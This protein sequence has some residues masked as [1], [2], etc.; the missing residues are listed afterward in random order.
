ME[1]FVAIYEVEAFVAIYEV[2]TFVAI[3]E[4][5]AFVTIS[6]IEAFVE[7]H[8]IKTF[9]A[10]YGKEHLRGYLWEGTPS[11]HTLWEVPYRNHMKETLLWRTLKEKN[12]IGSSIGIVK[13]S[14]KGWVKNVSNVLKML[15]VRN[16]HKARHDVYGMKKKVFAKVKLKNK[17]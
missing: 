5:E 1:V 14:Q 3:Y 13:E 16:D 10:I 9:V 7:I 11:W 6:E 12:G 2:E 15:R 8:E 4:M 17:E